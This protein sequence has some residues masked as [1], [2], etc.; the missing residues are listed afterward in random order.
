MR[1]FSR[2]EV[3]GDELRYAFVNIKSLKL[4]VRGHFVGFDNC[5]QHVGSYVG[6]SLCSE[7]EVFTY[8]LYCLCE[9]LEPNSAF[10]YLF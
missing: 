6:Q 1:I 5:E 2:S 4:F 7:F 10:I 8:I 3:G 9:I